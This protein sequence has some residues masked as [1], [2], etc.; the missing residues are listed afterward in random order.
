MAVELF[1]LRHRPRKAVEDETRRRHRARQPLFDHLQNDLVRHQLAALHDRLG[2]RPSSV[3]RLMASRSM[4]PVERCGTCMLCAKRF[5]WV[6][7]PSSRRPQKISARLRAIHRPNARLI[8]RGGPA[9]GP[10][11]KPFVIPHHQLR[12]QL[13]HRIH[14]HADHDQQ[15]SAAEIKLHVQSP[16]R[17]NRHMCG[18]TSC[19]PATSAAGEFRKSST[20]AAGKRSPDRR[21]RRTSSASKCD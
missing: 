19:R 8:N 2:Q 21:R 12:F 4:S 16:S 10:C 5:A 18:R 6:P 13:L 3:P 7:F 17:T 15:R 1:G 11:H 9:R 14:G 20:P